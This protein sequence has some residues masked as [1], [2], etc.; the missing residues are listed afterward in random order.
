MDTND[1]K[2]KPSSSQESDDQLH[3]LHSTFLRLMDTNHNTSL[4]T[5][6]KN[7]RKI[8][9]SLFLTH[10]HPNRSNNQSSS[11]QP[12][13]NI[14]K[15]LQVRMGSGWRITWGQHMGSRFERKGRVNDRQRPT[16]TQRWWQQEEEARSCGCGCAR[17]H[18]SPHVGVN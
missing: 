8:T 6:L 12:F 2:K 1:L 9:L 11:S 10:F 16:V 18:F 5:I 15:N 3:H 4:E 14:S 13:K 7:P 17:T